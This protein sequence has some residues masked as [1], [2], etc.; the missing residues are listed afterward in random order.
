MFHN[1]WSYFT[2]R[3]LISNYILLKNKFYVKI[4]REK[5]Y[6]LQT[7][8][9]FNNID[10]VLKKKLK[11]VQPIFAVAKTYR[12]EFRI[13]SRRKLQENNSVFLQTV[14]LFKLYLMVYLVSF[15]ANILRDRKVRKEK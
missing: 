2:F 9:Y 14:E 8:V 1:K 5:L 12:T 10:F 15:K 11:F 4:Q 6:K 3:I 7:K 13:F